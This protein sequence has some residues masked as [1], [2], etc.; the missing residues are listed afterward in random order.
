VAAVVCATMPLW[1][2]V[3]ASLTGERPSPREWLGL[4]VGFAGVVV[5]VGGAWR[6]G[7]PLY[8]G[9][10][11]LSPLSWACGSILSRRLR[12]PGGAG[13][14]AMQMITGGIAL[15]IVALVRGERIPASA[16]LDAWLAVLYL[17]V[18]GSLVA[19]SAY[20]WLLRNARP[21]VATSYAYVNPAIA[22][23][24]GAIVGGEMLGG[25]TIAATGL[26]VGA[27]AL[28]VTGRRR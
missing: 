20:G 10:L 2:A 27:V 13:G 5:L 18:A 9:L 6:G 17:M 14:S 8:F 25:T 4:A 11:V 16:P 12:G 19:F 23:V 24:V 15:A 26:I 28:V 1:A 3:I 7:D 22:V 21:A